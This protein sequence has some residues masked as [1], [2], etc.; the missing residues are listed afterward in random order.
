MRRRDFFKVIAGSAAAWPLAACAH[1]P[2]R[3]LRIDLQALAARRRRL[4]GRSHGEDHHLDAQPR[5]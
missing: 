4:L 3:M 2:D 1:R 5:D